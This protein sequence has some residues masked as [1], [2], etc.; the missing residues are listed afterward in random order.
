MKEDY[1]SILGYKI[2]SL[3]KKQCLEEILIGKRLI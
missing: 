1:I 2:Y 3:S